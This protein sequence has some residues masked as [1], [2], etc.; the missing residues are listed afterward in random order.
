MLEHDIRSAPAGV[1]LGGGVKR[2]LEGR[3]GVNQLKIRPRR[4]ARL[5]VTAG[6]KAVTLRYKLR[7]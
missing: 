3:A 6:G 5:T 2:A 4:G 1:Q 7:A